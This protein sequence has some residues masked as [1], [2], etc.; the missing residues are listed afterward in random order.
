[1]F[2]SL[3]PHQKFRF[4]FQIPE[5]PQWL[6]SRNRL[7]HAEKSLR[8]L[9]G[10]VPGNLVAQEFNELQSHSERSKSCD[11][12]IKEDLQCSHGSSTLAEKFALLKS[13]STLKPFLIIIALSSMSQFSGVNG[14]RPFIIQIFNAYNSPIEPHLATTIL[15]FIDNLGIVA[16]MCLVCFT[17][18][19]KLYII[20]ATGVFFSALVTAGYGLMFLPSGTVSFDQTLHSVQL[21]NQN[22]LAYIPLISLICWS[23]FS[24]CS[25]LS[26][27]WVV[28]AEIFSFK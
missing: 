16:F 10:W 14:M 21:E 19:R 1:M 8:W 18:K 5:T 9:R 17:G 2:I 20:M 12:C 11:S 27:P 24:Y 6:L 23:F 4:Q 22:F 3:K 28:M 26:M 13:K 15:S 7:R 25:V